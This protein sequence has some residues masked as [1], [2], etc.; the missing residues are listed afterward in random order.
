MKPLV[1]KPHLIEAKGLSQLYWDGQLRLR[2]SP[3]LRKRDTTNYYLYF[4]TP[5]DL[6]GTSGWFI[7]DNK[8]NYLEPT[9]SVVEKHVVCF[10][11]NPT[12]VGKHGIR[13]ISWEGLANFQTYFNENERVPEEWGVDPMRDFTL[14][15]I[16]DKGI[17]AQTKHKGGVH[18]HREAKKLIL[19]A[20]GHLL[21]AAEENDTYN[22]S[23]E[24]KE[25]TLG[26]ATRLI[27]IYS[28]LK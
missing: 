23:P 18:H 8:L 24:W 2:P 17:P 14:Y 4:T 22:L 9:I 26:L 27:Q 12:L 15:E 6:S 19:G 5:K 16:I 13:E 3:Y 1:Y 20:Y 21:K 28:K 11:N 7:E 10:T 25:D